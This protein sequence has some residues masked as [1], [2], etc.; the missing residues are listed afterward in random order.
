MLLRQLCSYGIGF[1]RRRPQEPR[2]EAG[3]GVAASWAR[4]LVLAVKLLDLV[5]G[6]D[7]ALDLVCFRVGSV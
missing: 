4:S 2:G 1:V 7:P 3:Y 6:V 5:L